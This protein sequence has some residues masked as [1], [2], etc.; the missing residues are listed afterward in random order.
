MKR[1]YA[2]VI[3]IFMMLGHNYVINQ[4][5]SLQKDIEQTHKVTV[6]EFNLLYS[7]PSVLAILT[8]I[9]VGILY[10]KYPNFTLMFG[11]SVLLIGQLLASMFGAQGKEHYFSI[12]IGGRTLEASGAEIL[13]M[14]QGN[15]ASSWMGNLAGFVFI[16]PEVGQI[17]NAFFTPYAAI[18]W[19]VSTSLWIGVVFCSISF[20]A[21]C[22]LYCHL[23]KIEKFKKNKNL[24]KQI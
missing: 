13:Y 6:T 3:L 4:P 12:F 8:I 15:L 2:G 21:C 19:G 10:H 23:K 1:K 14:I 22:Y 18:H 17:M 9:P 24:S 11:I 20:V 7:I 5:Q 16:L